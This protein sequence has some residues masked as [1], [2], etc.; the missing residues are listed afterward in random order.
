MAGGYRSH[1]ARWIG[2]A[3]QTPVIVPGGYRS[4]EAFWLGGASAIFGI[5]PPPVPVEINA[6]A[7]ALVRKKKPI[8]DDDILVVILSQHLS[9]IFNR[10]NDD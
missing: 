4:F 7:R 1:E 5:V 9:R 6:G 8:D 2:G 10:N 3:S